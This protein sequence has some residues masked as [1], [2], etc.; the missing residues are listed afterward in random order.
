MLKSIKIYYN[1]KYQSIL[2][3]H[4]EDV[5]LTSMDINAIMKLVALFSEFLLLTFTS[6][7]EF[8]TSISQLLLANS[9]F[10]LLFTSI[11]EESFINRRYV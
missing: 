7:S 4:Q 8:F 9:E 11:L 3:L 10:F 2:R 5:T 6:I 1:I